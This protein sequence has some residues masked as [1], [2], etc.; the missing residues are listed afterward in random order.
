MGLSAQSLLVK[1]HQQRQKIEI[2][3]KIKTDLRISVRPNLSSKTLFHFTPRIEN[4]YS[5]IQNGLRAYYNYEK[6]PKGKSYYVAP[7]VCFCDIPLSTIKYHVSKY[8]RYGIGINRTAARECGFTPVFYVHSDSKHVNF[9]KA[10]LNKQS[11]TP[12]IKPFFGFVPILDNNKK[13]KKGN[14]ENSMMKK[15]GD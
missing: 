1:E 6:L 14:K 4:L 2:M 12:F 7:M 3:E 8:G 9:R 15:N 13:I 11:F 10:Y 5:I